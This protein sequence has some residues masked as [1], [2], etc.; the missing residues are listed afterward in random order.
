MAIRRWAACPE[1]HKAGELVSAQ[2][3][4]GKRQRMRE[5]LR[6]QAIRG[7]HQKKTR[8]AIPDFPRST[9]VTC[10][11]ERT[12]GDYLNAERDENGIGFCGP[13]PPGVG[14]RIQFLAIG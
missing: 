1:K 8:E 9:F 10:P 3:R 5:T 7:G 14:D 12:V 4:S 2:I 6:Q 11:L 13:T